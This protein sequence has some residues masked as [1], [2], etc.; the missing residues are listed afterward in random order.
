MGGFIVG[1]INVSGMLCLMV[2]PVVAA[3]IAWPRIRRRLLARTSQIDVYRSQCRTC[4]Y[5]LRGIASPQCPECGT[6]REMRKTPIELQ[7]M[8][9]VARAKGRFERP[10]LCRPAT[11]RD[12][13]GLDRDY[14]EATA[15]QLSWLHFRPIGD[16]VMAGVAPGKAFVVRVFLSVDG[17][18]CVLVYNVPQRRAPARLQ[19]IPLR[20]CEALTEFTDGRFVETNNTEDLYVGTAP[21]EILRKR[22]PLQTDVL[23]VLAEHEQR[24]QFEL[25]ASA[26][27][28]V[29]YSTLED[30][31]A[32]L[33][34]QHRLVKNFR[35]RIGYVDPEEVR[36]QAILD[37]ASEGSARQLA[38]AV[39]RVRRKYAI[40]SRP[41]D[42]SQEPVGADQ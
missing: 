38:E 16:L 26:V 28:C 7:A 24:C 37:G 21:P 27:L 3:V 17:K 33:E 32:G 2:F 19:G 31:I 14:Y 12:F 34:R 29:Y 20:L 40:P 11:E 1:V 41:G 22:L 5:D 10:L 23:A 8:E 42:P 18:T 35:R 6:V 30:V 13:A 9:I 4:G 15:R 39:D 36:Q 25:T